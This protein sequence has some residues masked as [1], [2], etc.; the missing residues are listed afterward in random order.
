MC[1]KKE[2]NKGGKIRGFGKRPT[3]D[4]RRGSVWE[5]WNSLPLTQ[6]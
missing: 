2:K 6:G 3:Q 1:Y 5:G 4:D